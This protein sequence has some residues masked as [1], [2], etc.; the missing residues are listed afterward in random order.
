MLVYLLAWVA[1]VV[2][3]IVN[4]ALRETTYGKRMSEL[5][6]HQVSCATG[7]AAFGVVT[8]LVVRLWPPASAGQAAAIGAMWLALTVAFEFLFGHYALRNPWSDLL[9]DYDLRRGRLWVLVLVWV[10]VAPWLFYTLGPGR[11]GR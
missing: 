6:A 11:I 7:M 4:G 9:H 1:M 3:A 8:W 10:A 5:S 2:V